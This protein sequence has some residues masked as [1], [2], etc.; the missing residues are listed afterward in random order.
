M[1]IKTPDKD[2]TEERPRPLLVS[3]FPVYTTQQN[4]D[5]N[6]ISM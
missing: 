6:Q 5:S 1:Y 3:T 4:S 2:L